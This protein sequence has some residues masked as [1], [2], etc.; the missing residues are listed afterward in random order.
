VTVLSVDREN[1]PDIPALI[2]ASSAL[3]LSG[4][5]FKGPISAVRVG[6]VEDKFVLNPT[7]AQLAESPLDLVVAGTADKILMLEGGGKEVSEQKILEAIEFAQKNLKPGIDIQE[8]L[9]KEMSTKAEE[10]AEE[11]AEIHKAVKSFLSGKIE[12]AA[13]EMDK[14]LREEKIKKFEEEVMANFEGD[15]K[16]AELKLAFE[17]VLEKEVREVILKEGIRPDGRGI[18]EIRPISI[19]VGILPRTHGSALFTR[20]QTQ[21]LTV[22]TLGAPGAEQTIETMEEETTKRYMHHYNF[23]PYSTGEVRPLRS[24]SRREIGHGVLAEKALEPMIPSKEDFPYTIRLVSEVLSSNG[25]SSMASVCGSTLSLMDAGVPIKAPVA[26]IAIG[27]ISDEKFQKTGK[28]KYQI[29]V[30]IQGVEDFAGDMDF[31]I[32]GTEGGITAIQLDTKTSGLSIKLLEEAMAKG[33]KARNEILKKITAV[34]PEPRPKLSAYAPTVTVIHINPEKIRDVIGPGGRVIN[35]IIA[36]T[37]VAIDIEDNGEVIISA[38]NGGEMDKAVEWVKNLTHEVK[39]GEIF[40]GRVTRIMDFGAFV[41]IL[42]S[43]EGL[44]HIS[45]LADYRV[46]KVTDVVKVGDMIPVMVVEIDT[47]GRIN[48]SHKAAKGFKPG[49]KA[50]IKDIPKRPPRPP[51]RRR[52]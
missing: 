22:T 30:D 34:I 50:D 43:Q 24:V 52:F 42:P 1:E 31:K 41:E 16:Q 29:L 3:I 33:K 23:P 12:K 15:Y 21:V 26:G 19:E 4:A 9:K 5:P 45:Q 14:D 7:V 40:M 51:R 44:V 38:E 17:T 2:A 13:R 28:G 39:V 18:D 46:E 20:G 25:S 48:L 37:N 8:K 6:I 11:E 47:Q 27:L 32:A 36:E 35:Q 10:K 49:D